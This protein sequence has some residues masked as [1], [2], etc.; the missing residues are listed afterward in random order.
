M[1]ERETAPSLTLPGRPSAPISALPADRLTWLFV[2]PSCMP[3]DC[4]SHLCFCLR[5]PSYLLKTVRHICAC[6]PTNVVV[7]P[8][9][10]PS[11][12]LSTKDSAPCLLLSVC[13][14]D[15]P[16]YQSLKALLHLLAAYLLGTDIEP[17]RPGHC[18]SDRPSASAYQLL[19]C[20]PRPSCPGGLKGKKRYLTCVEYCD[21]WFF[22]A[23]GACLSVCLA[24]TVTL[25]TWE[26]PLSL[27][28]PHLWRKRSFWTQRRRL[29]QGGPTERGEALLVTGRSTARRN[30]D[31]Q[32]QCPPRGAQR[33]GPLPLDRPAATPRISGPRWA[34]CLSLIHI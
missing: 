12:D 10:R 14:S 7:R 8:S 22:G 15:K 34:G 23:A 32:R 30:P 19:L 9:V 11:T 18:L 5:L 24:V 26:P 2:R 3:R 27:G 6:R 1:R 28:G 31:Q 4:A 16:I 13:L 21:L 25:Y 29:L 33:R 17:R 20:L